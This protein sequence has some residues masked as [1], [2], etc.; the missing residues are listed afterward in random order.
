MNKYNGDIKSFADMTKEW[1]VETV[2]DKELTKRNFTQLN[3]LEKKAMESITPS[4][5]R[6][7]ELAWMR[8]QFEPVE[9]SL[10]DAFLAGFKASRNGLNC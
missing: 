6:P 8:W 7:E 9:T 3:D 1:G 10:K 5:K 4:K 2:T